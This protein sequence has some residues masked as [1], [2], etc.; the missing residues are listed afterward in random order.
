MATQAPLPPL[1]PLEICRRL[2]IPIDQVALRLDVTTCWTRKLA[3][4]PR[5][6]RRVLIAELE[7]ALEHVRLAASLA[8]MLPPGAQV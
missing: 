6:R 1:Q 7:T 3:Q 5:H 8:S 4:D 2:G